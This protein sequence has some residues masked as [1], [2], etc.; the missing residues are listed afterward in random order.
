MQKCQISLGLPRLVMAT[1][2]M[3][4]ALGVPTPK[5]DGERSGLMM[6]PK[7]SRSNQRKSGL[8]V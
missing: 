8:I 5:K 4:G 2:P 3:V 1:A 7:E 6:S